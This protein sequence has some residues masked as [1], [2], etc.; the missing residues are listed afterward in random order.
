MS[1][2]WQPWEQKVLDT[3]LEGER[4]R[5]LPARLKKRMII[6][7]WLVAKFEPDRRYSHAEI[8]AFLKQFHPDTASIRREFI[9]HGLMS[10]QSDIYWREK[11]PN[12]EDSVS[13]DE[14]DDPA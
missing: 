10:R 1:T 2:G 13:S 4:I 3:F 7:R 11:P 12:P 9:V 8:N 5:Q 6:L 14:V